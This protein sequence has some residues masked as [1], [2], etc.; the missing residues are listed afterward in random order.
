MEEL[1]DEYPRVASASSQDIARGAF[2]N[3]VSETLRE[4]GMLRRILPPTDPVVHEIAVDHAVESQ[5]HS[6]PNP[7]GQ[8][9]VEEAN[10]HSFISQVTSLDELERML[11]PIV[12]LDHNSDELREL[13]GSPH[14]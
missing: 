10:R 12:G 5:L 7:V 9:S 2:I 14:I 11:G 8:I 13:D 6:P 4:E 1:D 3:F